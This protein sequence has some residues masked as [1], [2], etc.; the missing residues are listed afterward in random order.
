M[1]KKSRESVKN[2]PMMYIKQ[3]EFEMK[4]MN[5]QKIYVAKEVTKTN[6]K[7]HQVASQTVSFDK[8]LEE[9][10]KE[11]LENDQKKPI[12]EVE[13]ANKEK[14]QEKTDETTE[15][16]VHS[17]EQKKRFRELSVEEKID[18]LIHLPY[19][20]PRI[21]CLFKTNE[22]SYRGIVVDYKDGKVVLR[23][24]TKPQKITLDI[25]EINDI[26]MLGF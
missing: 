13:L 26:Q 12:D 19:G 17:D 3:P 10:K 1:S 9:E 21:K 4:N 15:K 6:K 7:D 8:R 25:E 14:I 23:V 18:Y 22:K 24:V 20:V 5:M 11:L 2:Q 16:A